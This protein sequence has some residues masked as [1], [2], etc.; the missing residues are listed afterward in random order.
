MFQL[1]NIITSIREERGRER[2]DLKGWGM[3]A[4]RKETSGNGD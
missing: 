3:G 1:L 4:K 2:R